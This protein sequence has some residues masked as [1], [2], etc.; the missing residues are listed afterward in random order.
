MSDRKARRARRRAKEKARRQRENAQLA[1]KIG[2]T[3]EGALTP[4]HE[5]VG[6]S[7][8]PSMKQVDA[9]QPAL[10]ARAARRG[11]AVPEEK[12]PQLVDELTSIIDDPEVPAKTKVAAFN[13]LRQADLAQHEIDNPGLAGSKRAAAQVNVS[14]QHNTQNVANVTVDD[15]RAAIELLNRMIDDPRP[16]T[17]DSPAPGESS[18]PG[19]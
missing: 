17:E 1:G 4:D 9:P 5:R 2:T 7:S 6:K 10:I 19:D 3:P 18:P 16:G 14:V 12:K 13:A 11:W 15:R 8:H